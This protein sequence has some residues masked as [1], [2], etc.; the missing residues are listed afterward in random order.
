[1]TRGERVNKFRF[2]DNILHGRPFNARNFFT[3]FTALI[4]V[5][6]YEMQHSMRSKKISK[7][8]S[9]KASFIEYIY[10]NFF[11]AFFLVGSSLYLW[12]AIVLLVVEKPKLKAQPED[13]DVLQ[14]FFVGIELQKTLPFRSK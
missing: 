4:K 10:Y 1:M 7:A 14:R 6:T 12:I 13:K 9:S 5:S 11:I 3:L 8:I 2:C